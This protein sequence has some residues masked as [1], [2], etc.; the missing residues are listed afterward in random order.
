M[1][2]MSEPEIR[3]GHARLNQAAEMLG[4]ILAES[5]SPADHLIDQYFR[6]HRQMGSKDR[7]FAAETVY[8]CLRRKGELEAFMAPCLPAEL[9][10]G[11]RA[12]W[13]VATYLLKYSGWSGRALS[14]ASF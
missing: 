3:H 2:T 8:G 14:E 5:R 6:N 12:R 11:E 1:A 7:A 9:D 10:V 13:L 4:V